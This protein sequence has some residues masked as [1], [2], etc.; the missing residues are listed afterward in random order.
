MSDPRQQLTNHLWQ[1]IHEV[2]H[3]LSLPPLPDN[4]TEMFNDLLDSMALVEFL[5]LLGQDCGVAP[6]VIEQ[7]VDRE[8]TTI[9][10]LGSAMLNAGL[11]LTVEVKRDAPA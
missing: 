7:C 11:T 6:G 5:I 8:F 9:A 1:R 3:N 10:A 2:R 4:S